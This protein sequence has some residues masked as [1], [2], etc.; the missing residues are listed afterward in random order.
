MWVAIIISS[1]F[2]FLIV[3]SRELCPIGSFNFFIYFPKISYLSNN[4]FKIDFLEVGSFIFYPI[5]PMQDANTDKDTKTN[6]KTHTKNKDDKT[7]KTKTRRKAHEEDRTTKNSNAYPPF[8]SLFPEL[9]RR[10]WSPESRSGR[11]GCL[12]LFLV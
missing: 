8:S 7:K 6:T 5:N 4:W 10:T 9:R 3:S 11:P 12:V 2:G 1:Y